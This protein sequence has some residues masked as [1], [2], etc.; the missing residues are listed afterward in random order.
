M[1]IEGV[2]RVMQNSTSFLT[3]LSPF[4]EWLS[5]PSICDFSAIKL[6]DDSV[7]LDKIAKYQSKDLTMLF[8]KSWKL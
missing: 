3:L 8:S 6:A 7:I 5:K 2:I 4:L 1:L